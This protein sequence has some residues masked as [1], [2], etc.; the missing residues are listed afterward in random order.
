M[1]FKKPTKHTMSIEAGSECE[2][3]WKKVFDGSQDWVI[4]SYIKNTNKLK[5][6]AS[7][8]G[9][10][11]FQDNLRD[12]VVQF[13]L[14]K[15]LIEMHNQKI[16][17]FIFVFYCGEGVTL[18]TRRATVIKHSQQF[19]DQIGSYN[20]FLNATKEEELEYEALAQR[21]RLADQK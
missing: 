7:G 17:K 11:D 10:E 21:L 18:G 8:V 4:F 15:V 1:P 20:L 14:L 19:A 5:V 9:L 16:P 6:A 3:E 12:G 13:C 2:T